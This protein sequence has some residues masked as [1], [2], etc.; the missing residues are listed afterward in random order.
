MAAPT[1]PGI[2]HNDARKTLKDASL[3]EIAD[4]IKWYTDMLTAR[5]RDPFFTKHLPKWKNN[6]ETLR[7]E[8]GSRIGQPYKKPGDTLPP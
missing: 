3:K 4:S 1:Y 2:L 5:G 8:R 7:A 6:L